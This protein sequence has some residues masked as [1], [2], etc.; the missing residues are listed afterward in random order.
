MSVIGS[1]IL[2][3]ASGSAAGLNVDDVFSTFLFDA[4]ASAKTVTNGIDISGEGGLVL[5]KSRT[6]NDLH[7]FIDTERG[8]TKI[9][10]SSRSSGESTSTN[11]ITSFNSDGFTLGNDVDGYG[12]NSPSGAN[13]VSYT[14]RKAPEFFDCVAYSGTGSIATHSH[15]LTVIPEMMIVKCRSSSENWRVYVAPVGATKALQLNSVSAASTSAIYWNDT[16]PTSSVFT[17]AN[18]DGVN[19]SGKTYVNYLFATLSGISKVG[20]YSGYTSNAVNVDCGFAAG[21]KFILIKRTDSSGDWYVWDTTRGIVSGN[22]PYLLLNDT[23]AEVTN[24]DYI[25]P[26]TTGFTV[27][28]SAPAAL[29]AT[30]G[31]YLFLAIA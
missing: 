26:L 19:G 15:N 13:M 11:G 10:Q 17:V 12:N 20:S 8:A 21:A 5:I 2:A 29:N 18:Y 22:D 9:L 4:T 16:A 28:A 25:D 27:T 3:G 31:T 7:N 6:T 14:F 24:T 1:S 30:G 23:A